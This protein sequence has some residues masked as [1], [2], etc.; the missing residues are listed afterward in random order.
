M[1]ILT[2]ILTVLIVV[3]APCWAQSSTP[4][5]S[6]P[7]ENT[8][9]LTYH[10]TVLLPQYRFLDTSGNPSRVGEYDSLQQSLGGDLTLNLVNVPEHLSV[11]STLSVVS[12]DDY[13]VKSRLTIGKWFDFRF[14]GRSFIRHL[15]NNFSDGSGHSGFYAD[16]I[17]PDIFRTDTISPDAVLGIRRRMNSGQARVQLPDIPVKLFVKGGWQARDGHGQQQ[18]FD[19]GGSGDPVVDQAS[20]CANCHSASVY[21]PYNYTTRNIAGGAEVALGRLI[22]LTYQ[23]E[24]RSFNDR[25]QNPVNYFGTSGTTLRWRT[26]RISRSA[27]TLITYYRVTPPRTTR[28][29]SPWPLPITYRSMATPATRAPPISLPAIPRMLSMPTP[30]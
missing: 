15:D 29:R 28:C 7:G 27:T 2:A 25:M 9:D 14:D 22:T 21:R 12:Q 8:S 17:S 18:Y 5:S 20:G 10:F 6:A 19:M 30:R 11:K 24:Y 13:D 26:S 4:Q 23:H 1:K 16:V 3:A